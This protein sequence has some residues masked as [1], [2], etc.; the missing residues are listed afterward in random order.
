MKRINIQLVAAFFTFSLFIVGC[1]KNQ[2]KNDAAEIAQQSTLAQVNMTNMDVMAAE[3]INGNFITFKANC[4]ALNY[5]TLSL[6]K[7]ITINYGDTN[8]TCAD[9]KTR[10]GKVIISTNGAFNGIGEANKMTISTKDFYVSGNKIDGTRIITRTNATTWKIATSSIVTIADDRGSYS[11]N[12]DFVKKYISGD[13]TPYANDDE[14]EITG[15]GSGVNTKE[16]DYTFEVLNALQVQTGCRWI[17]GGI[18]KISSPSMKDD[19]TLEYGD[20]SCDNKAIL[21]YKKKETQI[22]L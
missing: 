10:Q 3:A 12:S 18:L 22:T 7:T 5:D 20:G 2:D 6:A 9:G 17:K 21:K 15:S 19:A 16:K 14:Y 8:C 13:N 1:Q 11:W 4:V